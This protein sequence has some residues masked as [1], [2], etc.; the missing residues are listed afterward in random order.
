M[1]EHNAWAFNENVVDPVRLGFVP[2][3]PYFICVHKL[4]YIP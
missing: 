1:G 2:T 3:V 4:K